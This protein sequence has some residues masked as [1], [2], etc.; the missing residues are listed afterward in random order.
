MI[1]EEA[2]EI[3]RLYERYQGI[4]CSCHI[5][6]PCF[7]CTEQPSDEEYADALDVMKLVSKGD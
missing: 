3:T 5:S 2:E 7:K 1:R 6:P 4:C